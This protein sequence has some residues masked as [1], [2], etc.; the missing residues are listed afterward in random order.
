MTNSCWRTRK[1]YARP[2]EKNASLLAELRGGRRE[3]SDISDQIRRLRQE[4]ADLASRNTFQEDRVLELS[5][6]I[7]KLVVSYL[8]RGGCAGGGSGGAAGPQDS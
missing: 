6:R 4:L 3:L 8:K 5:R 2:L 7:D 1:D